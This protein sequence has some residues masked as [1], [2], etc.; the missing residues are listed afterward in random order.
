MFGLFKGLFGKS[1]MGKAV[2]TALEMCV[3]DEMEAD[4]A[5]A[6]KRAE[7]Q[8]DR[9]REEASEAEFRTN[10][11]RIRNLSYALEKAA[12]MEEVLG[13]KEYLPAFY[14]SLFYDV[15]CEAGGR[16]EQK[17]EA[18]TALLACCPE[19]YV[20]SGR[21][22]IDHMN[23][24]NEVCRLIRAMR[25]Y[26]LV[27]LDLAHKAGRMQDGERFLEAFGAGVNAAGEFCDC[28]YPGLGVGAA[29]RLVGDRWLARLQEAITGA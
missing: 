18:L 14:C 8:A 13:I 6:R 20:Q 4:A 17:P 9:K 12:G 27:V 7:Q 24:G 23:A 21:E 10:M 28:R 29:A 1:T 22:L 26:P 2:E 15:I 3:L 11:N 16:A 25:N 5:T 19:R